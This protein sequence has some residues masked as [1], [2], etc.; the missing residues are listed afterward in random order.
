MTLFR[1]GGLWWVR[2]RDPTDPGVEIE[3]ETPLADSEPPSVV[4]AF[5]AC[6]QAV[7]MVDARLSVSGGTISCRLPRVADLAG[8]IEAEYR[9]Q[10]RKTLPRALAVLRRFAAAVGPET[11]LEELTTCRIAE[12][13]AMRVGEIS[14]GTVRTELQY[15]HRAMALAALYGK[16]G[17]VPPFP[18]VKASPARK[19]FLEPE[20]LQAILQ[21]MP[22]G[23]R[24]IVETMAW[25]G[26]RTNEVR[27][28]KWSAVDWKCGEIRLYSDETKEAAPRVYPFS[29]LPP[30]DATLRGCRERCEILE[31]LY[32]RSI[33]Y[34][35]VNQSGLPIGYF[36]VKYWWEKARD[37]AG[38]PGKLLHD[39]RR[40]AAKLVSAAGVPIQVAMSLLGHKT[41][42]MWRRYGIPTDGALRQGV[43][44]L[45][46]HLRKEAHD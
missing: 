20:Q 45:A 42:A 31:K 26:W 16:L 21:F 23:H 32:S 25:T 14:H 12:W 28:L 15:I 37:R 7:P 44:Q 13:V 24:A 18:R 10:E 39:L 2:W 41:L 46:K 27:Q 35:F 9:I 36:A 8:I 40:S 5:W 11:A 1:R 29:Q 3:E 6:R 43:Q 19:G 4:K 33:P 30:L 22:A 34:V 17:K 38:F